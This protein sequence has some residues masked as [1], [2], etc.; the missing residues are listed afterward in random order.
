MRTSGTKKKRQVTNVACLFNEHVK[1]LVGS[2]NSPYPNVLVM[3]LVRRLAT[4]RE[5]IADQVE[6][7]PVYEK[8]AGYR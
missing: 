2:G 7:L 1:G 4:D 5:I 8:I 3:E 6:L